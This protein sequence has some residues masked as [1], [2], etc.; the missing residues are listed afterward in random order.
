MP[1]FSIQENTNRSDIRLA[2]GFAN[3]MQ[4]HFDLSGASRSARVFGKLIAYEKNRVLLTR[5]HV[6]KQR[7]RSNLDRNILAGY[8]QVSQEKSK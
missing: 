3:T 7:T 8:R 6:P 1:G 5:S 4:I 2:D